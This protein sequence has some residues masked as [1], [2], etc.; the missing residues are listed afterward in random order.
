MQTKWAP[1]LRPCAIPILG[2]ANASQTVYHSNSWN[3]PRLSDRVPFHFLEW[4]P[5]QTTKQI[6]HLSLYTQTY[7][8]HE[9]TCAPYVFKDMWHQ[10]LLWKHNSYEYIRVIRVADGDAWRSNQHICLFNVNNSNTVG[11]IGNVTTYKFVCSMF[12]ATCQS[13]IVPSYATNVL[14]YRAKQIVCRTS[15]CVCHTNAIVCQMN[16]GC[17]RVSH[18]CIAWLVFSKNDE[19]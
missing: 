13:H 10:L 3:G 5:P 4:H 7:L 9:H 2:T 17:V 16:H 15:A 11:V 19:P 18:E 14:T 8:V 6:E 12:N 1:P